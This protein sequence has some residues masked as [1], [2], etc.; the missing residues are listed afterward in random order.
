[1]RVQ[2]GRIT[3]A[4]SD[5]GAQIADFDRLPGQ[6]RTGVFALAP[7]MRSP[8][9]IGRYAPLPSGLHGAPDASSSTIDERFARDVLGAVVNVRA[10]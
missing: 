3:R 7:R 2:A 4:T 5:Q 6:A 9:G 10:G 1:M 8:H